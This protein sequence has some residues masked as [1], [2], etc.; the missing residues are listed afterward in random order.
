[1]LV[2]IVHQRQFSA[3]NTSNIVMPLK[4]FRQHY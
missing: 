2:L 4:L 1:M 3:A